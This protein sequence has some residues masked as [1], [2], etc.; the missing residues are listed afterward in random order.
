MADWSSVIM[1]TRFVYPPIPI[2]TMDWCVWNDN[3]C[4]CEE[5]HAPVGYGA[6]P[7]EALA[8]FWEVWE[9]R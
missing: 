3:D 5:C 9:A 8:D 6:T 4:G 7:D 2:R 1:K